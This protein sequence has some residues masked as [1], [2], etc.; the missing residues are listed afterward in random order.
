MDIA[1]VG[2]GNI[3]GTS[4]QLLARAGHRVAVANSRGPESIQEEV[5]SWEGDVRALELPDALAFGE[6][7]LLAIPFGRY[8]LM[9]V[10][11]VQGKVVIDATNYY[12]DRDGQL[13]TLDT[14]EETSSA[15]IEAHLVHAHVVKAINTIYWEHLRDAGAPAGTEGRRAIPIA[16]DDAEAKRT[17]TALLDDMGFDAVDAGR[18]EDGGRRMQPGTPVYG[19]EEDADG[20]RRLLDAAEDVR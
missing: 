17:V 14:G 20:V 1:V 19:A 6:V 16:G 10:A 15:L 12:P 8:R 18:L 11:P 7:V 9:E 5:A 3:G 4:A 2:S 13:A